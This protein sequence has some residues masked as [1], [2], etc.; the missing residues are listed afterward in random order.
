[1]QR[2]AE[3]GPPSR[4]E[5]AGAVRR[6]DEIDPPTAALRA[7]EPRRPLGHRKIGTVALGLLGG[8]E[9]DLVAA[10]LA[11]DA[12]QQVRPGGGCRASPDPD[13][14]FD[15]KPAD[16]PPSRRVQLHYV[17]ST[18]SGRRFPVPT[19]VRSPYSTLMSCGRLSIRVQQRN[20]PTGVTGG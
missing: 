8:V 15:Q 7:T 14:A 20:A 12:Q 1:V 6:D 2:K 17:Q 10:I 11:P 9:I 13:S 16:F 4:P 19:I 18:K 5:A 3:A